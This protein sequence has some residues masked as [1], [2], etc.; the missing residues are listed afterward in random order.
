MEII[1]I[2]EVGTK[3]AGEIQSELNRRAVTTRD[4]Y[5]LTSLWGVNKWRGDGRRDCMDAVVRTK[6]EARAEEVGSYRTGATII[7]LPLNYWSKSPKT[8]Y[9]QIA[10]L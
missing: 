4:L 2:T 8:R 5:L 7:E 9:D 6:Q 1:I 10:L 3:K